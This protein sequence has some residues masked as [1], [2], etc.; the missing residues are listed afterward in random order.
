MDAKEFEEAVNAQ[1]NIGNVSNSALKPVVVNHGNVFNTETWYT[2]YCGECRA[3][4][5]KNQKQC[6]CGRFADWS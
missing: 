1:L 4:M 5:C 3:S 6:W 2:F